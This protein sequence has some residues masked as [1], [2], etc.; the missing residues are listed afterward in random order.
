MPPM[1]SDTLYFMVRGA[2]WS[3]RLPSKRRTTLQ[4]HF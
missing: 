4:A 1:N 2:I 3:N